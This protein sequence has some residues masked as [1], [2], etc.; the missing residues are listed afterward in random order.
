MKTTIVIVAT[1][2]DVKCDTNHTEPSQTAYV[3][4][5][6][7]FS[8]CHICNGHL[9]IFFDS[10]LYKY[11]LCMCPSRNQLI[12]PLLLR[13][14]LLSL[15]LVWKP[16]VVVCSVGKDETTTTTTAAAPITMWQWFKLVRMHLS[17]SNHL[18]SC[19]FSDFLTFVSDRIVRVPVF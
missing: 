11:D 7:L 8:G 19:S 2:V 15:M 5:C 16:N 3:T 4:I 17:S 18:F 14:L 1:D 6:V 13:R 10:S 12:L 9:A